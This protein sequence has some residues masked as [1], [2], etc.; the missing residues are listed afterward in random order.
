MNIVFNP[1]PINLSTVEFAPVTL[2]FTLSADSSYFF[3]GWTSE[4]TSDNF[5]VETP[6]NQHIQPA[7]SWTDGADYYINSTTGVLEEAVSGDIYAGT[8]TNDPFNALIV[9]DRP[10]WMDDIAGYC[11]RDNGICIWENKAYTWGNN[12]YGQLGNGTK[13]SSRSRHI[14]VI[15][16]PG[17]LQDKNVT[18][19]D[20]GSRHALCVADGEIYAWGSNYWGQLGNGTYIPFPEPDGITEPVKVDMTGVLSGKTVTAVCATGNSSFCIADGE[21]YAWGRNDYG[22]L[23]DGTTTFRTTPVAVVKDAGILLGKTVTA[24]SGGLYHTLCIADG[25]VYAWGNNSHGQLGDGTTAGSTTPVA[26]AKDA[27][28]LLGK[29]VTAIGAGG[30]R[31]HCVADGEAFSWGGNGSGQLGDGT[32]TQRDRPVK[33]DMTGVL[34]GKTVTA[35]TGG[36]LHAICIADGEVYCWG[37]NKY[38]Q[39]GDG[40]KTDSTTPVAVLKD[41]GVL[42][43]RTVTKIAGDY[44]TSHC[45][46]DNIPF[47]W[48]EKNYGIVGIPWEIPRQTITYDSFNGKPGLG[49]ISLFNQTLNPN[50]IDRVLPIPVTYNGTT[51]QWDFNVNFEGLVIEIN[52]DG[53]GTIAEKYDFI[54]NVSEKSISNVTVTYT[55]QSPGSHQ[56]TLNLEGTTLTINGEN[57]VFY[58]IKY[59]AGAN[60]SISGD[61]DQTIEYGS[62]TT[63]VTAVPDV[64]YDFVQWNDGNTNPSRTDVATGDVTYTATFALK[65]HNIKYEAGVGGSISGNADQNVEHGSSTTEV[66]AVPDVNYD[67]VQWND[68]NTNP[69]R[70]DV[71]TGDVTYTATF[72]L[73]VHNIKYEAG[74]NGSISGD[75]DQN[76]EHGSSTTEVTAVPDLGYGFYQWDDGNNNISRSDVALGDVTYTAIFGELRTINYIAGEGGSI[77]GNAVQHVVDGHYTTPVSA[78]PDE[79]WIFVRWDDL[80]VSDSRT[81]LVAGNKTYIALFVKSDLGYADK[82]FYQYRD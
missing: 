79:G 16:E 71:A 61:P 13:S 19:V 54:P 68:G 52:P 8:G 48:G 27:G 10:I 36:I 33:V 73:K 47:N 41:T 5:S 32:K 15:R 67:F 53:T 75:P 46:A 6:V 63:E 23:G 81:D 2:D 31:S 50:I 70:T 58:N 29:T 77:I 43:G 80:N 55:P 65:V 20:M 14:A 35:I 72:A 22:Q 45:I 57:Q 24:I 9:E 1:N 62:S 12:T 18:A 56:D 82:L 37:W 64:N 3:T 66:T 30:Y 39:L 34:S 59:E 78:S 4:P 7:I 21:V 26:V 49:D 60:G 25:E 76:V 69:S 38:G 42:L 17:L 74:A 44:R 51:N 11:V 28:I 40:T